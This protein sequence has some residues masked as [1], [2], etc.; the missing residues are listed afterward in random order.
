MYV[1]KVCFYGI[2][3]LALLLSCLL[4]GRLKADSPSLIMS[5]VKVRNDSTGFDEFIE[6]YNP[7]SSPVSLNDYFIGYANTANPTTG[8][9][10]DRFVI[11]QGLLEPGQS[12]VLAKND[13]DP[14]LSLVQ[15]SPFTS[16]SDSGGTLQLST[17]TGAVIDEL[18]WTSTASAATSGVVYMPG[19]TAA[20]S[21]SIT[22]SKTTET[23]YSITPANWLLA[24]PSPTSSSLL[25][26]LPTV[27]EETDQN[28]PAPDESPSP[29]AE[30]RQIE[31]T[32]LLPNPAKPSTD[33]ADEFIELHNISS[34]TANLKDY[35]LQ[36]GN[37][38]TFS[39]T[40]PD[41]VI[42]P[43]Q[44]AVFKVTQTHLLL[45]NSGGH[46]RLLN[47]SGEVISITDTYGVAA[48]GKAWALI[49]DVWQWTDVITPGTSNI[50]SGAE[51]STKKTLS[52]TIKPTAAKKV[53]TKTSSVAKKAA[54]KPKSTASS[55][56]RVS[57]A[58][59]K[60]NTTT[61][62]KNTS[63][64]AKNAPAVHMLVL[65]G[66]GASTVLYGLYE[67]RQDIGNT[68]RRLRGHRS[69]RREIGSQAQGPGS[70]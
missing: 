21:Q 26:L 44:Y 4:I 23:T 60:S 48:P 16:L 2:C 41:Y 30:S 45:S 25:P 1:L 66:V 10:F 13:T 27:I 12:F 57:S 46:S 19:T 14:H 28:D 51:E 37:S 59:K 42:Q 56:G 49:D 5:E 31:I 62:S 54:P 47:P 38:F 70:D 67:Y 43:D 11:A 3:G 35:K 63:T 52:S 65:A 20:R 17:S 50:A 9:S 8:V 33:D 36:S 40:F 69:F 22:R 6:L 34:E 32:E 64:T 53:T 61:S 18:R 7:S 29:S 15:K 39:Y 55:K 58:S 68:L 24:I